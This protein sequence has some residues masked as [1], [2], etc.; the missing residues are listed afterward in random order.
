MDRQSRIP[1]SRG[2]ICGVLLILLGLWGGLGPF[3]GPY[4]HF[5]YGRDKPWTYD[6]AHLYY[7]IIPGAAVLLAG[8][9]VLGTRN[10]GAG[11][12]GGLLAALG[13][14]W[15]VTGS[16]FLT[17]V[18]KRPISTGGP[19]VTGTSG[20]Q[21]QALRLYLE[22]TTL[23]GWLGIVILVVGGLAVGR[24]SLV[25]ARDVAAEDTD[26]YYPGFPA[27]QSASPPGLSQYPGST[28]QFPTAP[29]DQFPSMPTGQSPTTPGQYPTTP[30]QF[31][32]ADPF[33]PA[34]FPDT[35]TAQFPP[36]ESTS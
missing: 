22:T 12:V 35:T 29:A 16:G 4:F 13:G 27:S 30:G 5:G 24:F 28:G 6:S 7:S 26:S 2:G 19:I 20:V 11:I 25:A 33:T 10:R 14:A 21:P 18:V 3:V 15:F 31:P 17:Y 34:K 8:L 23:F 9:L 36:P 32:A 1:R